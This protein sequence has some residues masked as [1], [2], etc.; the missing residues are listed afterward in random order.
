MLTLPADL[1]QFIAFLATP[2]FG[3]WVVSQFLEN[4]A[5]FQAL[6]AAAKTRTVMFL[7]ILLGLLSF[8]LTQWAT[9]AV[10]AQWQPLYSVI[11]GALVAFASGQTYHNLA[12]DDNT[13][14]TP[15]PKEVAPEVSD[16]STRTLL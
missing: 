3:A 12:H 8:G 2:V 14:V 6:D 11:V 13:E 5:W 9:P 15:A 4:S 16:V 7:Y 10:L 1:S